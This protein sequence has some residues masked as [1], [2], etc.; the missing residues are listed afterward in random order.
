MK[1]KFLT[2]VFALCMS[3][4]FAQIGPV[5]G[6]NPGDVDPGN[7]EPP[8]IEDPDPC[9][10]GNYCSYPTKPLFWH[11]QLE[12]SQFNFNFT[13]DRDYTTKV[14]VGYNCNGGAP[15]KLNVITNRITSNSNFGTP[16]SFGIYSKAENNTDWIELNAGRMEA[17]SSARNTAP[18]GLFATAEGPGNAYAVRGQIINSTRSEGVQCAG[19]FMVI[20]DSSWRNVG[21]T[22]VAFGSNKTATPSNNRF[23]IGVAGFATDNFMGISP[24]AMTLYY[25]LSH[26]SIWGATGNYNNYSTPSNYYAGWFDGD[27]MI[28]GAGY[29]TGW[30][31]IL[32]DRRFKKEI[33]SIE[34]ASSLIAQLNPSTYYMDTNNEYGLHFSSKKQYG[35]ISQEVEQIIPDLITEVHKPAT[36]DREG[37][38]VA[39][40]VDYK[41]ID[42]MAFIALLTKGMQEQQKKIEELAAANQDLKQQIQQTGI[43]QLNA[44]E[45]GFQ[46]SQNVPNP[47]TH[48]TVVKYTIPTSVN[49]AYMAVYD[50]T[51][52]QITT[53]AIDQKGSASITL[54]AEKLAAGIYIYSIVADGKIMDSKR[55][56]VAEK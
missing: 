21:V 3:A 7:N 34:N 41:G 25:P 19:E 32:S 20:K 44:V 53:F 56:V 42:Y 29:Y 51:G 10:L 43:Q 50:L 47:F 31:T 39:K 48:E 9:C 15:G 35:F 23:N 4:A 1:K 14:N 54:T 30:G 36:V 38:E 12:L 6:G 17:K 52:K 13:G 26:V 27:V 37:K 2:S 45:T 40:A 33:H 18:T 22:G 16:Q 49:N 8:V 11:R 5:G 55:M 24:F 46:M 28:N